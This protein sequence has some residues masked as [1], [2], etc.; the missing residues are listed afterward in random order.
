MSKK[1]FKDD[2]QPAKDAQ[3]TMP[4]ADEPA[5]GIFPDC[6]GEADAAK[7][8]PTTMRTVVFPAGPGEDGAEQFAVSVQGVAYQISR[9]VPVTLPA[10]VL[11][12][13]DLAVETRYDSKM[14]ARDV[15]RFPYSVV[16]QGA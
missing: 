10:H 14:N 4:A 2:V 11:A 13:I 16:G 9:D 3:V 12:A 15:P 5:T 6:P 1:T 7:A 8:A